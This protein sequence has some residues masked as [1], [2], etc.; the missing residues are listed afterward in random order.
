MHCCCMGVCALS[1]VDEDLHGV[2]GS[3]YILNSPLAQYPVGTLW[4]SNAQDA[5]GLSR[6]GIAFAP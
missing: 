1:W 5:F 6:A 2:K 4:R 3:I